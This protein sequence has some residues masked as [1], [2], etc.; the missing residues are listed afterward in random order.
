MG[1][2]RR[3]EPELPPGPGRDLVD[4]F[5]RLRFARQL[6]GGQIAVKTGLSAG[7]VSD[8]L[9]GWKP[10]SPD[11]AMKL[12]SALGGSLDEAKLAGR[13]AEELAELNRYQRHKA[14]SAHDGETREDQPNDDRAR[15]SEPTAAEA[16]PRPP[17]V[18]ESS[19]IRRYR[20][21]GLPGQPERYLG[22]V[23][24]DIRRVRCAQVWVN[25]ENTE[26]QMA[27][28]NEFSVSSIVRYE[29][30]VRDEVGRVID[31]RIASELDRKVAGRLPVLPG[32]AIVT[33][34]GE[35]SRCDVRYLVHV[36]SVQG[37]PGA[38]FRQ[39][40]EIGRCVTNVLAE[41]DKIAAQPPLRTILFPLLGAGQGRAEP[42]PTMSALAGAALDYFASTPSSTIA[43]I[44]FLA[45]TDTELAACERVFASSHRVLT[46]QR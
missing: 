41:V 11:A 29:G 4:L 26:M 24:G 19:E 44:Y 17:R 45:Y 39:I 28:F 1:R 42:E 7:H 40:S 35:L 2:D 30:A 3:G 32:T 18:L 31:D 46:T 6:S 25:P 14:R 37:E 38:G 12:V 9:H 23:T 16:G 15:R 43:T 10:P 20:V 8:V 13:L 21:A 22:T 36:A 34:A 33:G 27:R 5:K